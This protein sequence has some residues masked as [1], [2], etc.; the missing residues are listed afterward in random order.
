M[1]RGEKMDSPNRQQE[2][3]DR[4]RI[5]WELI[6]ETVESRLCTNGSRGRARPGS[7]R[8][9]M[10]HGGCAVAA[11]CREARYECRSDTYDTTKP[12]CV[13]S[14][15]SSRLPLRAREQGATPA[16]QCT[17]PRGISRAG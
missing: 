6:S 16:Q 5:Q 7:A 17:A 14:N 3:G 9:H 13:S 15:S 12:D 11:R 4:F 1:V 2:Q 8:L 10:Y